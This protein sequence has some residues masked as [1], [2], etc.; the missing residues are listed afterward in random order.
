[1]LPK[2][3]IVE[4]A[5]NFLSNLQVAHQ[6][7]VEQDA[8]S[9]SECLR[10]LKAELRE[11]VT[12]LAWSPE[13]GRPA[14]FL[15]CRSAQSRLRTEAVLQLAMQ[16]GLPQLREYVIGRHVILYAH[17]EAEVALLALKHQRQLTY[18]VSD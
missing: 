7:F 5:Q 13:S 12:V 3:A 1:M 4:A 10:K 2:H 9:A 15:T 8:E 6:F 14:R 17:S 18:F 11:M 16:A